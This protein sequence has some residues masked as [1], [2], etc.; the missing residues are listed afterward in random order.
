M[1][2]SQHHPSWH[3]VVLGAV[4]CTVFAGVRVLEDVLHPS[5]SAVVNGPPRK[6]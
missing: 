1:C 3:T 5:V 2:H 6:H 4:T